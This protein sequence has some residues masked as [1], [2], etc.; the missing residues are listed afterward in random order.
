MKKTNIKRLSRQIIYGIFA[1]VLLFA[2]LP[3]IASA[4]PIS[5]RKV[6]IG[7]S[8]AS[9]S[10]TYSFIFTLPSS[11]VVKSASFAACTTATG[12]CTP[13]AGFSSSASTLTSQPTN[14]G[15]AADWIV[16]TGT[17]SELRLSKTGNVA[18]PTGSQNVSFSNVTNPNYANQ[19]FYMRISTFSDDAWTTS[20]DTGVVAT[21]TAGQVTV[22][23][24]IDEALTFTLA[25]TAI[26]LTQPTVSTAGTGTSTMAISTNAATG[27]SLSY[28]GT[29]LT[30]GINTITAMSTSSTSSPNNKQFGMNLVQNT[31]PAV[32]ST[33]SGS[34]SGAP[35]TGYD[36]A[37]HFKFLSGDTIVSA[38]LP[39]NTNTFTTSFIVNADGST[40]AGVYSTIL[41]YVATANF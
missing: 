28:T 34:G 40:A 21:S 24:G 2:Y 12:T 10:T 16:N 30:S 31:S 14:L 15:D 32:G 19:T 22:S 9:A 20:I 8:V 23:V 29:T 5:A 41:N 25:N 13:A 18:A 33:K 26:A 36:T 1:A 38:S 7:S 35:S 27:Y 39:T 11:T 6:T 17:S 3:N 37:D 4:S